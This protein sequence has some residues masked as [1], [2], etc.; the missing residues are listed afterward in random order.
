MNV[1]RY[2]SLGLVFSG[3]VATAQDSVGGNEFLFH[4]RNSLA[5][6]EVT[7]GWSLRPLVGEHG[8]FGAEF[9]FVIDTLL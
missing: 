9:L 1:S 2:L 3:L 7:L 4:R 6:M 8:Q 5:T